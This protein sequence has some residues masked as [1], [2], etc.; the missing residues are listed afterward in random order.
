MKFS[1]ACIAIFSVGAY[2]LPR[3]APVPAGVSVDAYQPCRVDGFF[4]R[5]AKCCDGDALGVASL[6]CKPVSKAPT[7]AEDFVTLCKEKTPKC[8]WADPTDGI[9]DA[10]CQTP[11]GVNELMNN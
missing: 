8:C 4:G 6:G 1:I 5:Q 7:S 2:A 3:A 9:V 11:V 10:S